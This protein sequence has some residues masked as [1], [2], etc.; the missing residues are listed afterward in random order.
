M[1]LSQ[2][3]SLILLMLLPMVAVAEP[4]TEQIEADIRFLADDLM[5]GRALGSRGLELSALYLESRFRAV[6]LKPAFGGSFRQPLTLMGSKPDPKASL[7]FSAGGKELSPD[8]PSQF[9]AFTSR[10]QAPTQV[11]GELVY[12]GYLI[13][14][15]ERNWN[16]IK[17][18]D[19]KGKILLVEVNEPGN[20]EGG[21][22]EGLQMTYYGRWTYKYEKAAE[23]GAAGVLLVHNDRRATYG[24]DVVRNSWTLEG[25]FV[26]GESS[27][28]GFEGWVTEA[29]ATEVCRLAGKDYAQL[30]A[31]AETPD[32]APEPL[33]IQVVLEHQHTYR[34]VSSANVAGYLP[35]RNP[36]SDP[37]VVVTA[38]YDHIGADQTGVYNGLVDNASACAALL[39]VAQQLAGEDLPVNV[40][41][42]A[43]T[44]EEQGLWGSR[45]LAFHPPV[46]EGRIWANINLELTNIWG[47]TRDVYGIG[48]EWSD[49]DGVLSEAAQQ[50]G[51][52]YIPE[53]G[54][55]NGFFYRSDQFSF[56]RA[57]VP[58]V[59][60]HEG[61]ESVGGDPEMI[62]RRRA[63]YRKKVYHTTDDQVTSMEKDWDL[64]GT[65]QMAGWAAQ[66]I[67]V[68][69]GR[70]E[71][72]R[73]TPESGFR[74]R[75][76]E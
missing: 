63:H 50:V 57:G 24:W 21:I 59:W 20:R 60:L 43:V 5:E 48:A 56:V 65:A 32:F 4:S 25:F 64:R 73:F 18:A 70:K 61:L 34:E 69:S 35:G 38:H 76:K 74:R 40:L 58:A 6:G 3:L 9:V 30:V 12:A 26:A 45:Y 53:Q 51:L 27:A 54:K 13:E 23:L 44:A 11:S 33:G 17:G 29:V 72:P 7:T 39:A 49:L 16:D 8:Y 42:A 31:R 52:R 15:P 66:V 47:P 68:L 10:A 2:F 37:V 28:A 22:F 1:S 46:D 14:A 67:R 36:K 62:G 19:L 41:F 75:L 71:R 55:E